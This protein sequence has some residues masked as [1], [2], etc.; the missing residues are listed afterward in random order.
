MRAL[1]VILGEITA[2]LQG[3]DVSHPPLPQLKSRKIQ[4]HVT[5]HCFDLKTSVQRHDLWQAA[6]VSQSL[7]QNHGALCH[8]WRR[9][10]LLEIKPLRPLRIFVTNHS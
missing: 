5:G 1:R 6:S 8:V 9:Y 2:L 3:V 4:E 7:Q 10:A